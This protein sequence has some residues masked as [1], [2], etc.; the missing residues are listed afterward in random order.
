MSGNKLFDNIDNRPHIVLAPDAYV[1]IQGETQ[2]PVCGE[3]R[4]VIDINKYVISIT[5][6]AGVEQSTGNATIALAIP[7]NEIDSLY[8]NN[9]LVLQTMM[10][11]NIYSKGY[12][13]VN[14][15]YKY[16]R[17]FWGLI[18]SV[19]VNFKDGT[20]HIN[21]SC[22]DILHW[23]ELTTSILNPGFIQQT[24]TTPP[25][26]GNNYAGY[27]AYGIIAALAQDVTGSFS[28]GKT[29]FNDASGN[30]NLAQP[31]TN[32]GD[33]ITYNV[34]GYW[35][36]KFAAIRESILLFGSSGRAYPLMNWGV[37]TDPYAIGQQIADVERESFNATRFP[38]VEGVEFS[39]EASEINPYKTELQKAGEINF[40]ETDAPEKLKIA[41]QAR[42]QTGYE[43]YCDTNGTIVF[44]PPF[45]NMD[46][47]K[48]KPNSWI[49]NYEVIDDNITD[50]SKDVYTHITASG[51]AF[52][53]NVDWGINT[54]V[55]TPHAGVYDFHLLKK[56]GWRRN[57]L[58]VEWAGNPTRLFY[59]LIDYMDRLNSKRSYG[60]I[61]IPHRPEMR[62][63]FPIFIE[64]YDSYYYV[65]AISHSYTVGAQATTTLTLKAKRSKFIA[66]TQL[67]RLK[68][69]LQGP[70]EVSFTPPGESG[71]GKHVMVEGGPDLNIGQ[72]SVKPQYDREGRLMGTPNVV[73][74]YKRATGTNFFQ[75]AYTSAT[76]DQI[77]ATASA[78]FSVQAAYDAS[79][80]LNKEL[81]D[82]IN[83]TQFIAK[84]KDN[85]RSNRYELSMNSMGD[86]YY[87]YDV[88][89]VVKEL[90]PIELT[91]S[92][93][94]SSWTNKKE[95]ELKELELDLLDTNTGDV[96]ILDEIMKTYSKKP[97]TKGRTL[98]GDAKSNGMSEDDFNRWNKY[99]KTLDEKLGRLNA[100]KRE[101][102]LATAAA[103]AGMKVHFVRPVSDEA[104]FEVI[105]HYRYGR[106]VDVATLGATSDSIVTGRPVATANQDIEV[107]ASVIDNVYLGNLAPDP[108]ATGAPV[109]ADAA[110][111]SATTPAAHENAIGPTV[112]AEADSRSQAWDLA[113]M[114]P[115][116]S[117]LDTI[118]DACSSCNPPSRFEIFSFL[119]DGERKAVL[120][121]NKN[122][123]DF[124]NTKYQNAVW[125]DSQKYKVGPRS[126]AS[127][128]PAAS[129]PSA[130][131]QIAGSY[132]PPT[133]TG[134][135]PYVAFGDTASYSDTQLYEAAANGDPDAIAE[136]ARRAQQYSSYQS[137]EEYQNAK[138]RYYEA[139]QANNNSERGPF[140][141][142]TPTFDGTVSPTL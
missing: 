46:V 64:K 137:S 69:N 21:L 82:Q 130:S 77:K 85:V 133:D 36:T 18:T 4:R 126:A 25:L 17:I 70:S 73:M 79:N 128:T 13:P 63:G 118:V 95:T 27:N 127:P 52:G 68:A 119:S 31:G 132:V 72:Q 84:I 8:V 48:N 11:V 100:G 51:N 57:N 94:Q 65:E 98:T 122:I 101:K 1:T 131:G 16:Y 138:R 50:S 91:P 40:Y 32:L 2:I 125:R 5:T 41:H 78:A 20:N 30:S 12:Y 115:N 80:K 89:K 135:N 96:S 47:T 3:C 75:K 58:S 74:V 71:T 42:D 66:P 56:Y 92:P 99:S 90:R 49:Y 19:Q 54:D 111:P 38:N 7:M 134:T 121:E 108:A 110:E 105:G 102:A 37:S 103:D 88:Y 112:Y 61:T 141:E 60:Q 29:S 28:L 9:Q 67:A 10:E 24:Q 140:P 142:Y 116:Q 124:I 26:F 6:D 136:L 23:W 33:Y 83:S 117:N 14:G 107:R 109:A 113:G 76:S 45:F 93:S 34:M 114:V 106:N 120:E 15:V 123:F 62:L 59:Y 86:Y 53:G 139:R 43:F 55:T 129:D 22:Q 97:L 39:T 104:G 87:A 35:A 81:A 44:K